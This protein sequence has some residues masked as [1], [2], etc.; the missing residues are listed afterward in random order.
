MTSSTR[1]VSDIRFVS[2][3]YIGCIG[4]LFRCLVGAEPGP[5]RSRRLVAVRQ[6]VRCWETTRT[7][8]GSSY[9]PSTHTS[10]H[11]VVGANPARCPTDRL[12]LLTWRMSRAELP[13]R[14]RN[15]PGAATARCWR[16][17]SCLRMSARRIRLPT[18]KRR[19]T[20][21]KY[22][23]SASTNVDMSSIQI[24]LGLPT[25]SGGWSESWTGKSASGRYVHSTVG[26]AQR[27][28]AN[29]RFSVSCSLVCKSTAQIF[30][31]Q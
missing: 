2:H 4:P 26:V 12:P 16:T 14:A 27:Q 31:K 28:Y 18:R 5:K 30:R 9:H 8:V 21:A 25:R 22:T 1:F 23:R 3:P 13:S 29:S 19:L 15:Y 20:G 17:L 24:S 7:A 10:R 11:S 6:T